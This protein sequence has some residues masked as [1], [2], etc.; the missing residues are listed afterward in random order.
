MSF[1]VPA[2][3]ADQPLI[4]TSLNEHGEELITKFMAEVYEVADRFSIAG[5]NIANALVPTD[6]W[7]NDPANI[8]ANGQVKPRCPEYMAMTQG[9]TANDRAAAKDNNDLNQYYT[10]RAA[11]LKAAVIT[12]L[13]DKVTASLI[14]DEADGLRLQSL[15]DILAKV[16]L[17]FATLQPAQAARIR[18]EA[19]TWDASSDHLANIAR[20][21]TKTS[22]LD[23]GGFR[24]SEKEKVS[25]IFFEACSQDPLAHSIAEDFA[26]ANPNQNTWTLA[27]ARAYF[28]E[29]LPVRK[30]THSMRKAGYGAHTTGPSPQTEFAPP[31]AAAAAAPTA[32]PAPPC[33]SPNDIQQLT[34]IIEDM[35]AELRSSQRHHTNN[36][37]SGTRAG[38]GGRTGRSNGRAST[39]GRTAPSSRNYCFAHGYDT[40]P[41]TACNTMKADPS[42]SA[43]M[44]AATSHLRL[45]GT[46]GVWYEG[47]T[48]NA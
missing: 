7:N 41:G 46:D 31:S 43:A 38:R 1:S 48:V 13:G 47:S 5:A 6:I 28:H 12:A 17:R 16:Q 14:D 44:K 24:V 45:Q 21:F 40:H 22:R 9:M 3:S 29:Q 26:K 2:V 4:R 35:R 27:A 18:A 33:A 25:M 19:S 39:N 11:A 23:R 15:G 42:Y 36:R 37:A 34:R 20:I 32:A 10:Q 30:A 8:L